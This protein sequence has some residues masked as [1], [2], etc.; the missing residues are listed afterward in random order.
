MMVCHEHV[1]FINLYASLNIFSEV[2]IMV[3]ALSGVQFGVK[4]TN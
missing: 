2:L 4:F 1:Y 3:I